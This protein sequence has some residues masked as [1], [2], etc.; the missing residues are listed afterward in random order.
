MSWKFFLRQRLTLP[1]FI[2]TRP[3]ASIEFDWFG[4]N[5]PRTWVG[6]IFGRVDVAAGERG[7]PETWS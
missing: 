2:T 4:V 7:R 3:D 5:V 6:A 1:T